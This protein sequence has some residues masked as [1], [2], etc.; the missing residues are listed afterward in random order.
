MIQY[1]Y[2]VGSFSTLDD[3]VA[4]IDGLDIE[5]RENLNRALNDSFRSLTTVESLDPDILMIIRGIVSAGLF[6][7]ASINSN[8]EMAFKSYV[9][10]KN[11]APAEHV[12]DLVLIGF[13]HPMTQEQLEMAART[14]DLLLENGVE[15]LV[16]EGIVSYGIYNG[17][18]GQDIYQAGQGLIYGIER[19][20]EGQVLALSIIIGID[21]DRDVKDIGTIISESIQFLEK[22]DLMD[23]KEITRKNLAL[24]N[25][26]ESLRQNI[27][28][29]IAEELYFIAIRD[30]WTPDEIN[31]VFNGVMVGNRE[32]L[33][34]NK[35][36]TALIIRIAQ[37]LKGVPPQKMVSEELKYVRQLEKKK[38]SL[39]D[40]DRNKHKRYM[41]E[42]D[43]KDVVYVKPR[44]DIPPKPST[45]KVYYPTTSRRSLNIE[46][47]KQSIK[48][49]LGPPSTPYRWGGNSFSGTDCSGFTQSVY[50]DQGVF[51][52]RNSRQQAGTGITIGLN[53]LQFGDLV[54]FSKYFNNYITHVGIY[55]GGGKFVH[56]SSSR[57]VTISSLNQKYYAAR[58]LRAGSKR[59]VY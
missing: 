28:R 8:A 41:K 22:K 29:S 13:S 4:T 54:F 23:S 38:L 39:I 57:G 44:K 49:F 53:E 27:P 11:G 42:I 5:E 34:L 14:L 47:M 17:W 15:P 32:G 37:G 35:V 3:M 52:P 16:I 25:L 55:I 59:I 7:E 45:P 21:Q 10:I 9:S 33:S 31:A 6:E 26:Q 46:L 58:L 56:A 24:Q 51:I 43:Q 19:G 30:K 2:A 50:K 20:L 12:E 40:S 1:S 18:S 48:E 36:A